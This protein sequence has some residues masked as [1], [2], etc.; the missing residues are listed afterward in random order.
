MENSSR[1]FCVV[2]G[3][4][5]NPFSGMLFNSL[6]RLDLVITACNFTN[7]KYQS[8]SSVLHFEMKFNFRLMNQKIQDLKMIQKL[9]LVSSMFCGNM[10]K[11][12]VFARENFHCFLYKVDFSIGILARI[13]NH[14]RTYIYSFRNNSFCLENLWRQSKL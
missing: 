11:I 1:G 4:V 14:V 10:S 5:Q 6:A 2:S 9:S 12:I 13:S 8:I 7:C 3:F